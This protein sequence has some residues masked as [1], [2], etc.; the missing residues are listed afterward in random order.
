[1]SLFG[2]EH[3]EHM[4][5]PIFWGLVVIENNNMQSFRCSNFDVVVYCHFSTHALSC[6]WD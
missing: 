4:I 3:F 6:H 2:V 5:E 1:M